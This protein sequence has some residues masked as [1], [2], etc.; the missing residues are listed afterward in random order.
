MTHKER[1]ETAWSFKEP[2]RVPIE[3]YIIRMAE[4]DP[5][6]QRL[7]QLIAE[8]ADN[9]YGAGA[10]NWGFLGWKSEDENRTIEDRPGEY[11][12]IERIHNTPVGK[13]T[14]ITRQPHAEEYA[15][16]YHWEKRFI[17]SPEELE[18]LIAQPP[19]VREVDMAA[20]EKTVA[21]VGEK[22]PV[23]VGL[24]HPLG[25][26]V[27]SATMEDAYTWFVTHRDLMHRFLEVMNNHVAEVVKALIG[28]GV[29]PYFAEGGHE[30]LIP[31]WAGMKFFDEFVFPYDKHVNDV[32]HR[33]G[34]KLRAHCH[35]NCMGYLERFVEMGINAVE[36]LEGPPLGDVDLAEAK[37]AVGDRMM[38]SGNVPSPYFATWT[39]DQVRESVRDAIRAAAPGGGFSLRTTGGGTGTCGA[40]DREQLG[41]II[42][43]AEAY[44][45]AGL[46]Y[47]TYPINI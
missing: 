14:A 26:L 38:L 19:P 8:H 6:A 17:T 3:A 15:P 22:G 23:L 34:G 46:E 9:V 47:G 2:D 43:N 30:M 33:H 25:K 35:G 12:R 4:Q 16:D 39:P 40:R 37:R 20:Y 31:P 45:L 42:A 13:F 29:R 28:A 24:L 41:R 18:R 36:P 21:E 7:M 5:R 27:R 1:F 11:V 32:I 10:Y 44:I